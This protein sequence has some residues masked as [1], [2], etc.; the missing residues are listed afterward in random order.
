M[1]STEA[2]RPSTSAP[3]TSTERGHWQDLLKSLL[4]KT[5]TMVNPESYE[6]APVGHQIRA[7]FYRAKPVGLGRDYLVVATD[8]VHGRAGQKEAVRQY[9]PFAQI[10][11]VSVM[12][13]EVLIH[14]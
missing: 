9:I 10:K 8:F 13:S 7:G 1:Q 3:Q 4:G 11:R 12:K 5:V 2:S 14:L 6:E